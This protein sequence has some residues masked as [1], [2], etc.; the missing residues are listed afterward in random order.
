MLTKQKKIAAIITFAAAGFFCGF[1]GIAQASTFFDASSLSGTSY[2]DLAGGN[3]YGNSNGG[4]ADTYAATISSTTLIPANSNIVVRIKV[5]S[6]GSGSHILNFRVQNMTRD[7]GTGDNNICDGNIGQVLTTTGYV[8]LNCTRANRDFTIQ[9]GDQVRWNTNGLSLDSTVAIN[10]ASHAPYLVLSNTPPATASTTIDTIAPS[11]TIASSSPITITITGHLGTNDLASTTAAGNTVRL[12]SWVGGVD[13]AFTSP[14]HT[15]TLS[16]DGS[17][18]RSYQVTTDLPAGN[19]K[20]YASITSAGTYDCSAID[21]GGVCVPI[22][23][24]NVASTTYFTLNSSYFEHITGTSTPTNLYTPQPC[25]ISDLSGCF[26]NALAALFYP[27]VSP[28][29]AFQTI[30]Q[31]AQGKAPFVYVYQIAAVRNALFTSS[32]TAPTSVDV[33]LWKLPGQTATSSLV[34][35]SSTLISNVP[36]ASTVKLIITAILWLMMA[37]YVYYRVIRMHDTNT[38]S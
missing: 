14:N 17:F 13:T 29:A 12:L 8:Y 24:I 36:Y 32:S 31:T 20:I 19:F 35:I 37:E 26:Q 1:F 2:T 5:D 9:A 30:S 21:T 10:G 23:G 27:T 7:D 22:G 15:W 25:G 18:T 28:G 16:T 3:P 38:P 6:I 34:M 33:P 11:G 4:Y